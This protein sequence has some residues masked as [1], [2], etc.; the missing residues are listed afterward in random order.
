MIRVGGYGEVDE[1]GQGTVVFEFT[2][3]FIDE[4]PPVDADPANKKSRYLSIAPPVVAAAGAPQS[5]KVEVVMAKVCAGGANVGRGCEGN[6]QCPG[7]TCVNSSAIGDVWW[8]GPEANIPNSP[9]ANLRGSLLQCSATPANAQAWASTVHLWGQAIVPFATYNVYMCDAAGAN[10]SDPLV[11]QTGEWGD[12][13]A[14]YGGGSQ[15]NFSDIN[16]IVFKFRNLGT[17]LPQPRVDLVGGGNAGN[18]NI[19]NQSA[20]FADISAGV[21]AFRGIAYPYTIPACP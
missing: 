16:E 18:P 5:I 14:P 17:S 8:A 20:N 9:Q 12:C 21:D 1:Q 13:V 10:C 7:S 4:D 19:P 2:P 3:E 11:M 15:P 6:S